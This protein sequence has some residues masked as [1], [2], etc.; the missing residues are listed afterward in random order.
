MRVTSPLAVIL[1]LFA[2]FFW[3]SNFQATKIALDSLPPWT[4]SV[5]RFAFAVL[6]IFIFLSLKGGIRSKV[7]RQNLP[8]FVILGTIGVAGFNGA[9]F[10]GLQS[11]NPITAAL[12]MATTPISANILEAIM[13]RRFPNSS[14]IFGMI[15]SLFGVA[16]VITN[17]QLF[18]EGS[19]H[20][21]SGDLIIF[22]GSLG[23]AIY[24]VG[25]RTFITDATP[26]ET[27]SWTMLF[28]TLILAI[29]AIFIESPLP[30][31]L[32]GK[33]ESHLASIYM[34]IAGSVFAY[35]FW[36]IGIATRGPG[37]TAIFFNFVP[38]FA[39]GIQITLGDAPSPAQLIGITITIAGVL[40][41]QGFFPTQFIS[42]R[43][44][45]KE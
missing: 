34:G 36:N 2:T 38:I 32:S 14:R 20:T 25:T 13:N 3:G 33:P 21:T 22:A 5:E 43:L 37:K 8:A 11:S 16:L 23:W 1:T 7:L 19:I 31:L 44:L 45:I 12:I 9:L 6:A 18:S 24:T 10:V 17:G 40:L 27:T 30:S 4:T 41:G 26:L 35:L 15:I 42:K 39:L 28:G 29:A